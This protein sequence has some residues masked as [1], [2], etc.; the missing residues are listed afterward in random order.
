[1]FKDSNGNLVAREQVIFPLVTVSE[2]GKVW[3]CVG[4]GFYIHSAGGFITAKHVFYK[5]D[6]TPLS[7]IYGVHSFADGRTAL[8]PAR[9][10][11]THESADLAVG[12]LT[13][14]RMFKGPSPTKAEKV[15]H[16][17]SLRRREPGIGELITSD[18]FPSTRVKQTGETEYT[19]SFQ[20][21]QSKGKII[22]YQERGNPFLTSRHY[23]TNM[24]IIDGASGG[25]VFDDNAKVIGINSTGMDVM[26]G[27]EPYSRI[28]P[29]S[30]ILD[31]VVPD[32]QGKI[33]IRELI[34]N[35]L[36]S[37]E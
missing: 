15:C 34:D 19:M 11:T 32:P 16:V 24:S 22:G 31:L 12:M 30:F 35:G 33:T 1:M 17:L 28:T 10:F 23:E 18:A 20:I 5:N 3:N 9:H 13:E 21:R 14:F 2:D 25:P 26:E 4:T 36:I 27:D 37:F 8:R 6:H 29:I 7:T